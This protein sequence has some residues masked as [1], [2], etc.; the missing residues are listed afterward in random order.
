MTFQNLDLGLIHAGPGGT[1]MQ[2]HALEATPQSLT[3]AIPSYVFLGSA[4]STANAASYSFTTLDFGTATAGR[5]IV[6]TEYSR[7]D[8][9]TT[10]AVSSAEAGGVSATI[11]RDDNTDARNQKAILAA[12]V[13]TGTTGDIDIE[14]SQTMERLGIGWYALYDLASHT[15]QATGS[16]TFGD[17]STATLTSI[18]VSDIV[19]AVSM[20]PTTTA[21]TISGVTEDFDTALE[22][23]RGA[24]ASIQAASTSNIAASFDSDAD[25]RFLWA[26]WR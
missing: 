18:A 25:N 20:V 8:S 19:I 10:P 6:A 11:V 17:P 21:F 14:M 1:G 23:I 3:G 26:R 12:A 13:P 4:T 2:G 5:L 22:T 24:G 9:A 7:D 15:R 16:G